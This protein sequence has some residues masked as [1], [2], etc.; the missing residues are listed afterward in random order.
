MSSKPL[1]E[2]IDD[3]LN[4]LND[5]DLA[6][7]A[8]EKILEL[9]KKLNPYGS[10]LEGAPHYLNFSITQIHHEYW[11]KFIIT[12]FVGFLNRMC[13][14]WKVPEGIPVVSVYDYLQDKSKLD[15]PKITI[16]KNDKSAIY[17]Y[18]LNRKWMEKRII[19]KQFLEEFLQ[20]NPDEHVR[21][22]YRPNKAD[23]SRVPLET[24]AA[25]VATKHLMATDKEFKAKEDF[26][27]DLNKVVN[28]DG[29]TK[30]K[31]VKKT[32]IGKDGQ[33]KEVWREVPV[34]QEPAKETTET[35]KEVSVEVKDIYEMIPPH[36]TFG[37]FKHYY[38]SHYEELRDAVNH[39]YCEKPELELAINP[40]SWHKTPEEAEAFRKK[41]SNEV[42]AEVF[43]AHSG[44]WNFFDSFKAQ[45]ESVNFYNENTA[46]LEE[47][48]KQLE[49]DEK[50]AQDM[51][52][53]RVTKAKAKNE[54]EVG[55]DAENFKKWRA[56][57]NDL[58]KMGAK[59][60]GDMADDDCPEDAVQ[61]DVWKVN[62]TTLQMTKEKIFTQAEAPTFIKDAQDAA[63]AKGDMP[64]PANY[65]PP[66]PL[67]AREDNV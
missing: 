13:D 28:A 15:T 27:T 56:Q 7:F 26:Y 1:A 60:I 18:E 51:L 29:T 41:H 3:A 4:E 33:K 5:K 2:L 25:K 17:E 64:K 42:I 57:N 34:Q 16:E 49:R 12:A 32:V 62:P 45:R 31:R 52:K 11:K 19:V 37:R 10:T 36:D 24:M 35:T 8:P 53:K 40:Y 66:A 22:A 55:P 50:L 67:P 9:K 30:T 46:V 59:Y 48:V 38:T 47:M 65:E 58:Q 20:F 44:K 21:S 23:K 54:L 14:E 61:I 43:T 39:L 63:I 6:T